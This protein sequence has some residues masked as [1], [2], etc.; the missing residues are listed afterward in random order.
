[1]SNQSINLL[2]GDIRHTTIGMHSVFIPVGIGYIG[3]YAQSQF[4]ANDITIDLY[5]N[6]KEL[7]SSF[8]NSERKTSIVGLSNY[9]WNSNYSLSILRY[10]KKK[11][12]KT[13]CIAGGPEF[14]DTKEEIKLF[15]SKHP[16]ID[17]YVYGHG[18]I[19]FSEIIK[20]YIDR[21]YNI[22]KLKE[23]D[24][25]GTALIAP[26]S[27]ELLMRKPTPKLDSMD[28]IPSPYLNGMLDKWLDID[29]YMPAIET[30]RG[31]PFQC[32]YC[33]TGYISNNVTHFNPSRIINEVDYIVQEVKNTSST[34]LLI[35]DANFGL[36]E[37]DLKIAEHIGTLIEE[38]NWPRNIQLATAKKNHDRV[39]KASSLMDNRSNFTLSRQSLNPLTCKA[40]NRNDDLPFDQYLE[41]KKELVKRGQQSMCEL[42]LP[43]P[44]ETKKSYFHSQKKLLDAGIRTATYTTMML[45]STL[46]SSVNYREKYKLKTKYRLIPR[47]F[48]D[49]FNEK[50]FETEEV[51]IATNTLSFKDY[52][53]CRGFAFLSALFS[54][55][56]FDFILRHLNELNLSLYDFIHNMWKETKLGKTCLSDLY[57]D[58]INETENE[59]FDHPDDIYTFFSTPLNYEKLLTNELGSNL[60]SK[61]QVKALCLKWSILVNFLY[62]VLKK[63]IKGKSES[64]IFESLNEAES[65]ISIVRNISKVFDRSVLGN[66]QTKTF[67]FDVPLWYKNCDKNLI[68]YKRQCTYKFSYNDSKI[69]PIIDNC[70]K[71]YGEDINNQMAYFLSRSWNIL[72]LW[73]NSTELEK[74][75]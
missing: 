14:P 2:L 59:L 47:A 54:R 75:I 51:C 6:G 8:D 65:W 36:Y 9:C 24:I 61:Y 45:K 48:G 34:C 26:H 21:D 60:I 74:K 22:E 46:L 30:T 73:G 18:E 49:Y 56:Q 20:N 12:P 1:M 31:C 64:E 3:A 58:F 16:E 42:I 13:L 29:G 7:I 43:L 19:V 52:L 32:G 27:K 40:I 38:Y 71:L 35:S 55:E 53:E 25:P 39:L 10:I 66:E 63:M 70:T 57:F 67:S 23:I 11:S 44:S 37:K 33:N 50:I 28:I 4:P 5:T 15:L 62:N 72:D 41:L 68:D 17:L 69:L